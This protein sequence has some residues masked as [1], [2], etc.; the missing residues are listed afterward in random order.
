MNSLLPSLAQ[1]AQPPPDILGP[2]DMRE[3][4]FGGSPWG[5]LTMAVLAGALTGAVLV[6]AMN[7][8]QRQGRTDARQK[9]RARLAALHD[10][11]P[12]LLPALVASILRQAIALRYDV[13]AASRTGRELETLLDDRPDRADAA[14]PS[15]S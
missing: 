15:R 12:T 2:L 1:A 7:R 9:L 5:L 11:D 14:P 13:P 8:R 3:P 10:A 4:S 6:L